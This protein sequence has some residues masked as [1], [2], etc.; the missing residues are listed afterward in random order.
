MLKILELVSCGA[1]LVSCIRSAKGNYAEKSRASEE[2]RNN[3]CI[4]LIYSSTCLGGHRGKRT[5]LKL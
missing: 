5:G 1:R 3:F 4:Q 2:E